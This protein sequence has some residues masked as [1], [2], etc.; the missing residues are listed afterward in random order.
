M[1]TDPG[2]APL[3]GFSRV[4]GH[5]SYAWDAPQSV[6]VEP[7]DTRPS[8][9]SDCRAKNLCV[10]NPPKSII[11]VANPFWL[12]LSNASVISVCRLVSPVW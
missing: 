12:V 10:N 2:K 6:P 9:P 11:N 4:G 1:Q 5:C 7:R 3:S 8:D